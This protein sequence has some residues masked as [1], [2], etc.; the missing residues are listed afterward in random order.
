MKKLLPL[1]GMMLISPL[2]YAGNIIV[3]SAASGSGIPSV[4]LS[5][6]SAIVSSVTIAAGT[7]ITGTQVG[8]TI[9]LN[10]SGSGGGT[11]SSTGTIDLPAG[12]FNTSGTNVI[13]TWVNQAG[14]G[15]QNFPNQYYVAAGRLSSSGSG[16]NTYLYAQIRLPYDLDR[17]KTVSI[18]YLIADS[19]SSSASGNY[20]LKA[21]IGCIVPGDN[22]ASNPSFGSVLGSTIAVSGYYPIIDTGLIPGLDFSSCTGDAQVAFV[23]VQRD[24]TV[25]SNTADYLYFLDASIVYTRK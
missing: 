8:N 5:G 7:N 9:T 10:A 15:Y 24:N 19:D 1:L 25:A 11:I 22:M 12:G 21:S 17:T 14:T 6:N 23:F 18:R 13:G 4:N 2:C 3:Q 16:S 20:G